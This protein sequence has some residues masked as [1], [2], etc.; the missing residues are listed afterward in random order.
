VPDDPQKGRFGGQAARNDFVLS[1]SFFPTRNRGWTRITLT[2][3]GP[4]TD[5][6]LARFYLHDSFFPAV[7]DGIFSNG[8]T[9]IEVTSWGG[10]TVGGWIPAYGIELEL[11]LATS[12]FAPEP[13]RTR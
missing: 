2:K 4:A 10:F 12:P 5:G 1:A 9:E 13:I 7:R 6:D 11:D 3:F 8:K